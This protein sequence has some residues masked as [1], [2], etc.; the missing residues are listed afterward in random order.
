MYS[1][2]Y[3]RH[4]QVF[5]GFLFLITGCQKKADEPVIQPPVIPPPSANTIVQRENQRLEAMITK[6]VIQS[7]LNGYVFTE[8]GQPVIGAEVSCGSQ[9]ISTDTKGFFYFPTV[10]T[11]NKDFT[12]ITVKK[13]GYMNGFRTFTANAKTVS[14]HTETIILQ[15]VKTATPVPVDG[16]SVSVDNINLRFK[17]GSLITASGNEYKGNVKVTA[18]YINPSAMNFPD[19]MPGTLMG[20]DTMGNF[21]GLISY[22]MASVELTDEAGNPLQVAGGKTV[23]MELPATINGPVEIPLWHLNEKFGLWV[24]QG[25]A[26][27]QG[28]VYAAEVNHFSVWNIDGNFVS[29]AYN[30]DLH[31]QTASGSALGNLKLYVEVENY[32]FNKLVTTDNNGDVTLSHCP[33]TEGLK[34]KILLPCDTIVLKIPVVTASLQQIITLDDPQLKVYEFAGTLS[35]CNNEVLKGQPFQ[36]FLNGSSLDAFKVLNGVTDELG[37]FHISTIVHEACQVNGLRAETKSLLDNQFRF[38]QPVDVITGL[39]NY[40]PSLC[41]SSPTGTQPFNDSD[42][43]NIPDPN[44]LKCVMD[45]AF[46]RSNPIYYIDVKNITGLLIDRYRSN[47][48]P[49]QSILGLQ[50]FTK[51][52]TL[53]IN[54][55]RVSDLLPIQNLAQLEEFNLGNN[56]ISDVSPLK[57]LIHLKKLSLAT[58]QVTDIS[59]LNGLIELEELDISFNN[60]ISDISSLKE[61]TKL[62]AFNFSNGSVSDISIMSGM[63]DMEQLQFANNQVSDISAVQNLAKLTLFTASFNKVA[64]ITALQ[65]LDNLNFVGLNNNQITNLTALQNKL[66]IEKLYLQNNLISDIS[67]LQ[68]VA[69]VIFLYLNN[70]QISSLQT[71]SDK[72][73]IPKVFEFGISGNPLQEGELYKFMSTHTGCTIQ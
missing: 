72:S 41:Y 46:I 59:A 53:F 3:F 69:N 24:L 15:E 61:C 71:L 23:H 31:F 48:E 22:G 30:L 62:K 50:Y 37:H 49:V 43:V 7:W 40:S 57:K 1:L 34:L 9:K 63:A 19:I 2:L 58:N 20:I 5:F 68:T 13:T 27:K 16:G 55:N 35:L 28:N 54:D 21:N 60:N 18:R 4:L 25:S 44:F 29:S 45:A 17:A 47:A 8:Q 52:K 51:L 64:D 11:V 70:N 38:S 10:L 39:N 26:K 73:I 36:L 6:E 66:K 42:I 32:S 67:P 14:Y 12:L 65:S 56:S 33:A